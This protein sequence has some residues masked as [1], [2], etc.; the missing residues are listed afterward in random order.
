MPLENHTMRLVDLV[1]GVIE[2][3]E[4]PRFKYFQFD[5]QYLPIEDYLKVKPENK[6][7]LYKLIKDG[8]IIIG[9][10]YI[11]QDAFLTSAESNIKD[12]QLGLKN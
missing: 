6:E 12:L 10:W 2:A 7:I 8:K 9:P 5:G 3:C 11:L 4:D 1:D